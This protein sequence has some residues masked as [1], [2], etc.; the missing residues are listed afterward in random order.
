M[1]ANPAVLG[2]QRA[3]Q[4]LLGRPASYLQVAEAALAI[5][6]HCTSERLT[7]LLDATGRTATEHEGDVASIVTALMADG[8]L[9]GASAA[10][11][12][13]INEPDGLLRPSPGLAELIESP[14]GLGRPLRVALAE[15]TTESIRQSLRI[16]GVK[17]P[18]RKAELIEAARHA[19]GDPEFVRNV[20]ATAPGPIR[21]LL[22]AFARGEEP[23]VDDYRPFDATHYRARQEARNWAVQR[24]LVTGGHY[25]YRMEMSSEVRLAL[26]G[27]D[28]RA[29]FTP[30]EPPLIV[31]PV[32]ADRLAGYSVAAATDFADHALAILDRVAIQPLPRLKSGGVGVRELAKLAKATQSDPRTARLVLELSV[33]AGLLG[34]VPGKVVVTNDFGR[35][36]DRDPADRLVVLLRAWWSFGGFASRATDGDGTTSPALAESADCPLCLAA[37]QA[38]LTVLAE[39]DGGVAAEQVA[40]RA[41]WRAPFA[42]LGVGTAT[43]EIPGDESDDPDQDPFAVLWRELHLLGLVADGAATAVGRAVL[44]R[45]WA[46]AVAALA[47]AMPPAAD[48]AMFGADL[49]AYVSG[50]PTSAVSTLLDSAADREG[51]GGAVGWRFSTGSVRRALDAGATAE[52][53]V[54]SLSAIADGALPQPLTYLIEEVGQ[55]HGVLRVSP[56]VS[57][58]RSDDTA[59]L[60]QLV[61]D[62]KLKSLGLRSLAPTVVVS[63]AEHD[64][65]LAALRTAGY[66]PMP[67]GGATQPA[68][69]AV[70][71][72]AARTPPA[73]RAR[74][75]G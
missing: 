68:R 10:Q 40:A 8:L 47:T 1:T 19:L 22:L 53:L 64:A 54:R 46:Q 23:V 14:L 65:L 45:Q 20:V 37:K 63:N 33:A 56:A 43:A 52:S 15:E 26:L 28:A 4:L 70:R 55:R 32:A 51:R 29:P 3:Y 50:A 2:A 7:A 11:G 58:I 75:R 69:A 31:R 39:V 21:D 67:E 66:F 17:A 44:A 41:R 36:R 5:D 35:W 74:R 16:L 13:L 71:A 25:G 59:L 42:H 62:R 60:A 72:S 9:V 49:T 48:R 6:A 34:F 38:L 24:G 57:A 12:V 61:A 30:V 27:P 18:T 73:R